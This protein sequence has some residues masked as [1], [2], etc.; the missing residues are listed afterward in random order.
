MTVEQKARVAAILQRTI[1]LWRNRAEDLEV[2]SQAD[3]ELLVEMIVEALDEA[4][5]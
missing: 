3:Q 4:A 1:D 2:L 5:G